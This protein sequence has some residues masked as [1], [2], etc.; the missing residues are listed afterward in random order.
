MKKYLI[1]LLLLS[2][3]EEVIVEEFSYSVFSSIEM[4]SILFEELGV[5]RVRVDFFTQVNGGDTALV[6][7][8][9]AM[10]PECFII[11]ATGGLLP[12]E[13]PA[14]INLWVEIFFTFEGQDGY[15]YLPALSKDVRKFVAVQLTLGIIDSEL[16]MSH[17]LDAK[18][19]YNTALTKSRLTW[20]MPEIR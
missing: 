10:R 16:R 5:T 9:V 6:T 12:Y 1:L 17:V 20:E 13:Y 19:V 7:R 3:T 2:C 8:E 18:T 4:A 14:I 11:D 15:S